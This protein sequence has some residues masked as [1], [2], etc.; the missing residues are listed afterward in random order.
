MG[1]KGVLAWVLIAGGVKMMTDGDEDCFW[2]LFV[3][4]ALL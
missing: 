3:G 2:P 1:L 4:C